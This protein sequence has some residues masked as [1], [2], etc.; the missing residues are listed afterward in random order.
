MEHHGQAQGAQR[1]EEGEGGMGR[2]VLDRTEP[3]L[4]VVGE[5]TGPE[6]PLPVREV[7]TV[8]GQSG[9]GAGRCQGS[10]FFPSGLQ[11]ALGGC[12]PFAPG[13][14]TSGTVVPW[15]NLFLHLNSWE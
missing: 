14:A 11:P 3:C 2:V 4:S 8:L 5:P 9:E 15:A 6:V 10:A 7:G 12:Q 13:A 1:R